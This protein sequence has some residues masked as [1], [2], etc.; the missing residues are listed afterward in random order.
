MDGPSEANRP[1]QS[2]LILPG[3]PS[4]ASIATFRAAYEPALVQA[5]CRISSESNA[6][7]RARL[8][9]ALTCSNTFPAR[10]EQ[11]R[12]SIYFHAQHFIGLLYRLVCSICTE[13]KIDFLFDN[14][15]DV[16]IVLVGSDGSLS[17]DGIPNTHALLQGPVIDLVTLGLS[18]R[19]WVH[20]FSIES[21]EGE[22]ALRSFLRIRLDHPLGL[23]QPTNFTRERLTGG[24]I[25]KRLDKQESESTSQNFTSRY[26]YSVAVGGTFDHLHAGHK[27][28]L[29]ATALIL[30]PAT[31]SEPQKERCLTIGITGDELLKNK[32]YAEV[33]E[34]WEERQAAVCQ[35]LLAI[36]HFGDPEDGIKESEQYRRE[37]PNGRAIHYSLDSGMVIKCVEISDPYGPT[38]TDESITALVV[39]GETRSGGRA[40]N[41]KR[42]E[43]GWSELAVFEIDV[44]DAESQEETDS[45]RTN[46]FHGKIS[47]TEIRKRLHERDSSSS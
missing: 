47:S 36:I 19:P 6:D 10:S 13:K 22:G 15:V 28:L 18:Q 24:T 12:D 29:T 30:E 42:A 8:D 14:D 34:S 3:P 27:L 16:R 43:R 1:S 11:P 5:L 2:L 32:R 23:R 40:V 33:L 31:S 44:L 45:N 26:H 7:F 20:V 25:V 21:E 37:G 39:S 4:E 17:S 35:F 41:G 38:I 46:D 9:I